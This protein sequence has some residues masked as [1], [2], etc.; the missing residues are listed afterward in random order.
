MFHWTGDMISFMQDA[1]AYGTYQKELCDWIC[2][3]L[4]E[5]EHVCDAGCGLGFLSLRLAE[6][7]SHVTAADISGEALAVL[8]AQAAARG[9]PNL[10]IR[11]TDL[12]AFSP[13]EPFD[14]MVFCLFGK[15]R[16]TLRMAKR[17]C[18]GRVVIV[19][20]AFT[21]HRFSVS[22][23]PI[24][25]EVTDQAAAF[26]R[27]RGVP[28]SLSVRAFEM[29]QPLRSLGDAARFFE[30]YSKDAPGAL[31]EEAIRSRLEETADA[32]FPFYLPQRK[33]LGR[34]TIDTQNIPEEFL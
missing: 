5:K 8:R 16:Q 12:L 28:F 33:A 30:I 24:K 13:D 18:R 7:F 25:D 14:A 10:G 15:M 17:C 23:V 27:E 6:R 32:Q 26:L 2:A 1:A 29:G 3:E 21:H 11:Q 19:K 22:A 20:K 4:P 9:V 34:F 31:T